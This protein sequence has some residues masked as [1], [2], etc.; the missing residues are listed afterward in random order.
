MGSMQPP[1][2]CSGNLDKGKLPGSVQGVITCAEAE[3][4]EHSP[5][6]QTKHIFLAGCWRRGARDQPGPS[7]ALTPIWHIPV[8]IHLTVQVWPGAGGS[9]A[10]KRFVMLGVPSWGGLGAHGG[11]LTC[12]LQPSGAAQL[13]PCPSYGW[14]RWKL[15]GETSRA[16]AGI[17]FP[18]RQQGLLGAMDCF[19]FENQI[20]LTNTGLCSI[21]SILRR[22]QGA[23]CLGSLSTGKNPHPL[24]FWPL[25]LELGRCDSTRI[26]QAVD[27]PWMLMLFNFQA[28]KCG[29][30]LGTLFD[31]RLKGTYDYYSIW[32]QES[33][34]NKS[35]IWGNIW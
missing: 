9:A 29:C 2:D 26:D 10:A 7:K 6:Q 15:M 33:V 28:C 30:K 27:L 24:R 34:K 32:T 20:N 35:S 3:V 19:L 8:L 4:G 5:P 22:L 16:G 14:K 11:L 1:H 25:I 21:K 18:L 13:C 23:V 12:A 31:S 17:T